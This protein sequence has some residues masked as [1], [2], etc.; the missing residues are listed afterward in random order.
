M[1]ISGSQAKVKERKL[2]KTKTDDEKDDTSFLNKNWK[3][4]ELKRYGSS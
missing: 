3:K 2:I 1:E 4:K